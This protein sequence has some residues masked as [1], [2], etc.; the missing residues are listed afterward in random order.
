MIRGVSAISKIYGDR[1][2]ATCPICAAQFEIDPDDKLTSLTETFIDGHF[3]LFRDATPEMVEANLDGSPM[4][5]EKKSMRTETLGMS[6][7][8]LRKA[9]GMTLKQLAE[10]TG[11]SISYL[12]DMERGRNCP[13]VKTLKKIAAAYGREVE[14]T[15]IQDCRETL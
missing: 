2:A 3:V 10:Q 5:Q 6:L 11:L 9:F 14:I 1:V 15:F 8:G 12:S 4:F 13:S 7:R